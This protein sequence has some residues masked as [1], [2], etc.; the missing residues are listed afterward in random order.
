MLSFNFNESHV[1]LIGMKSYKDRS[2]IQLPAVENNI[3]ELKNVLSD[4]TIIGLPENN[5]H[6][7]FNEKDITKIGKEISKIASQTKDT[8]LIYYAG[9]G[10]LNDDGDLCLTVKG[11]DCSVLD[12][13]SLPFKSLKSIVQKSPA[14]KKI[15][16]IDCC[17]SGRA[18]NFMS[19]TMSAVETTHLA[20]TYLITSVSSNKLSKAFDKDN[21]YTGFTSV[22]IKT[23]KQ[24]LNVYRKCLTLKEIYNNIKNDD[25]IFNEPQNASSQ[26]IDEFVFAFNKQFIKNDFEQVNDELISN[27]N[28]K[29]CSL[30]LDYLREIE[31]KN[32]QNRQR[33]V[34]LSNENLEYLGLKEG[35][36]VELEFISNNKITKEYATTFSKPL[37]SECSVLMPLVVRHLLS[38][39]STL[40]N[41]D[42][43]LIIRK[44]KL[45][46]VSYIII[47]SD[48]YITNTSIPPDI[49]NMPEDFPIICIRNFE[50]DRLR[51][52]SFDKVKINI[53]N[54]L[55][56]N[57]E[58]IMR[59]IKYHD[60]PGRAI[61]GISKSFLKFEKPYK[62][63]IEKI[64]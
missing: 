42:Y 12:I 45:D 8:L 10:K 4:K 34:S 31:Q 22:L 57:F 60:N 64:I 17:F 30:Q 24:G 21:M 49:D 44:A 28:T 14:Q 55:G 13:T 37:F 51:I 48:Q 26:T 47:S 43:K 3:K 52:H 63:K 5:I 19:N 36:W 6:T 9:H 59:A 39:D 38:L 25:T 16:I 33:F 56:Q 18:I 20:G 32:G 41:E 53:F 15:V 29:I 50:F 27:K 46:D 23:L 58:L 35:D 61:I 1:I 62:I 11:T 7:I 54:T 2:L 40:K